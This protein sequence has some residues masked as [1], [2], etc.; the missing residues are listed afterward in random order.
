MLLLLL[1]LLSDPPVAVD[2]TGMPPQLA[3]F[4]R[5]AAEQGWQIACEGRAGEEGVLRLS[6]PRGIA[7]DMLDD[8]FTGPRHRASS[9]A[10][11]F[12]DRPPP[13]NC[14][15]RPSEGQWSSTP[16][17]NLAFGPRDALAR[18]AAIARACGF[19]R[20]A[21]RERRDVDLPAGA[22][23]GAD[24]ATLDAGEDAGRRYGPLICFINMREDAAPSEASGDPI[25]VTA[26]SRHAVPRIP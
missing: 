5:A 14:D 24:W 21:V 18:L 10:F 19:S 2:V 11:Y 6:F 3:F 8:Y 20:A 13:G 23:A 15:H 7:Q 12:R 4:R 25:G 26:V 9:T 16:T 1:A 17:L 22:D